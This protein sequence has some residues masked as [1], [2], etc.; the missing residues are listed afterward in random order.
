MD[1]D[2]LEL[3]PDPYLGPSPKKPPTVAEANKTVQLKKELQN[4][5]RQARLDKVTDRE[6]KEKAFEPITERLDKVEKAVKPLGTTVKKASKKV[7]E[8]CI[9]VWCS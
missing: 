7:V 2:E 5:V 8:T 3:E 9:F 1:S 4:L 6:S